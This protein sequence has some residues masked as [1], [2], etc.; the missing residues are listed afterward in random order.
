MD[1]SPAAKSL[2]PV[3]MGFDTK[4]CLVRRNLCTSLV[5]KPIENVISP[6]KR[7]T[8]AE[9]LHHPTHCLYCPVDEFDQTHL[10]FLTLYTPY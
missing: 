5:R 3:K 2:K 9:R 7:K 1:I 4:K 6:L 10:T 8:V